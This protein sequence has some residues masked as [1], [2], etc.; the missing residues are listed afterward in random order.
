MM[1]IFIFCGT[2]TCL[3]GRVPVLLY[4]YAY[5]YLLYPHTQR[6][7]QHRISIRQPVFLT[8]VGDGFPV[9]SNLPIFIPYSCCSLTSA[10]KPQPSLSREG[11]PP[12]RWKG[13]N[14]PNFRCFSIGRQSLSFWDEV[15]FLRKHR[16]GRKSTE[17]LPRFRIYKPG[18][19]LC[20]YPTFVMP[21]GVPPGHRRG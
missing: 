3:E 12:Q 7:M 2:G 17:P 11:E 14:Y 15:R 1:F 13:G 10:P 18:S 8:T 5:L 20:L 19:C 16:R 9:P 21:H 4:F 6:L